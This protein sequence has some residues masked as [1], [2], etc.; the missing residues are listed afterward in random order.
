MGLIFVGVVFFAFK[1]FKPRPN[2]YSLNGNEL[3]VSSG[4]KMYRCETGEQITL[5]G[6]AAETTRLDKTAYSKTTSAGLLLQ[7]HYL[8]KKA[9]EEFDKTYRKSGSCPAPFFQQY[10]KHVLLVP[11]ITQ[12]EK[13]ILAW[14]LPNHNKINAWEDFSLTGRCIQKLIGAQSGGRTIAGETAFP[15]CETFMVDTINRSPHIAH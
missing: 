5:E 12:M 3:T 10:A 14:S 8:D 6:I 2:V 13:D 4:D 9:S 7:V 11:S 1:H 15:V